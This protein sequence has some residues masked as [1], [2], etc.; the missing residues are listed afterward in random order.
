MSLLQTRDT[1]GA[2]LVYPLGRQFA[3]LSRRQFALLS[4]CRD[5]LI[6]AR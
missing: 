1:L 3:L 5:E 4:R 2:V 6:L